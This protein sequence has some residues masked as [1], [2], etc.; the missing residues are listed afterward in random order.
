M[1]FQKIVVYKKLE[2]GEV[3]IIF[4]AEPSKKQLEYAKS[5]NIELE[6]IPI[7][8]EAFVFIVNSNNPINNLTIDQI[9]NIYTGIITNWKQVG[10]ENKPVIALQRA[11]GSGSQTAM[12]SFMNGEEMKECSQTLIGRRIGYSFRKKRTFGKV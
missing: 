9:K 4:C 5:K 6:L 8:R 3:D 2:D 1:I 7:G 10:G 11:E 12:L